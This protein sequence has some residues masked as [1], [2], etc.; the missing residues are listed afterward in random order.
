M[1]M[2]TTA[3]ATQRPYDYGS[4]SSWRS[5]Q[6][7][8][9]RSP[10]SS[11]RSPYPSHTQPYG[12]QRNPPGPPY[13]TYE[14]SQEGRSNP[15]PDLRIA[16]PSRA[17]D[18]PDTVWDD[19]R[20][21]YSD[22][23]S[24]TQDYYSQVFQSDTRASH[25][26]SSH[27][28]GLELGRES[29]QAA[30][31]ARPDSNIDP[32]SFMK[33]ES[34]RTQL[35]KVIVSSPSEASSINRGS[36]MDDSE[37]TISVA[38]IVPKEITPPPFQPPAGRVPS[39]V[40]GSRNFSR[41]NRTPAAPQLT[42]TE[43]EKRRVL[44]R[45][46][47][48]HV[49][50]QELSRA[51]SQ[52]SPSLSESSSSLHGPAFSPSQPRNEYA[53]RDVRTHAGGG[54]GFGYTAIH[55]HQSDLAHGQTLPHHESPL[56]PPPL[57]SQ[58]SSISSTSSGRLPRTP[59]E[60]QNLVVLPANPPDKHLSTAES[61]YSAYSYYQFDTANSSPTTMQHETGEK[62]DSERTQSTMVG[63]PYAHGLSTKGKSSALSPNPSEKSANPKTADD[64]LALGISHHEADRLAESA[65]CFEQSATMNGGCAV[66]MLMWGLSLRHGWGIPKDEQRAFKWLKRAAEHA[67]VDLQQGKNKSGR[68]AIRNE[69]ILAVY[70]VGQCFF[71]G[72][73]VPRDKAMGVS[74][75]QTAAQ[76]GD[77]D[78]Q[79]D[80]AFCL[81]NGKGCKKNLKAAAKWYRAAA[82]QGAS[83]VGLAWIYK[84]KY[85]E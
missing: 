68:E 78:A 25:Q 39:A 22:R 80:L 71:Q 60:T 1:L 63:T 62:V 26:L 67:V 33:Y 30:G 49:Q 69:L 56:G 55:S 23:M 31:N 18:G 66:G 32:F 54:F 27:L 4:G 58:S 53:Q 28:S 81:A 44:E 20:S 37:S 57:L 76:L 11:S 17:D 19:D 72:W 16:A 40:Q 10:S 15:P 59:Q 6:G 45:N 79:Q 84:P 51:Q 46:Q 83:T 50:E 74:Y 12:G 61:V 48:R 36:Y 8:P 82:A 64:F 35:P 14:H 85:A 29:W 75:F 41:P 38:P 21:V 34:P 52:W 42:G 2:A 77:P 13:Y 7:V 43:E 24:T 9:V 3:S 5:N 70:E 47:R 65:Q 73:G